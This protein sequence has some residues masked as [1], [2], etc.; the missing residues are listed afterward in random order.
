MPQYKSHLP[1]HWKARR[2][3][4]L[5]QPSMIMP[6]LWRNSIATHPLLQLVLDLVTT[7]PLVS[8]LSYLRYPEVG[9]GEGQSSCVCLLFFSINIWR[10]MWLAEKYVMFFS[11]FFGYMS[12]K[13]VL[14]KSNVSF[15]FLDSFN[16]N[17]RHFLK[18]DYIKRKKGQ[19][20]L[21][22]SARK[23]VVRSFFL[24]NWYRSADVEIFSSTKL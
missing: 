9:G 10:I 16:L 14:Q 11:I 19:E 6:T 24:L 7:F 17:I 1:G 2:E 21:C 15:L 12:L 20:N 3:T 8:S 13:L 22:S 4:M 5:G 23:L 18:L